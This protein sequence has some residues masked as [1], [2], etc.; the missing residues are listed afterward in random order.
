[1]LASLSSSLRAGLLGNFTASAA[2][3]PG[4]EQKKAPPAAP[5][6]ALGAWAD[7]VLNGKRC[8]RLGWVARA[9]MSMLRARAGPDQ[10]SLR[11]G[12]APARCAV[13]PTHVHT[14]ART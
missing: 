6:S 10:G 3:P 11:P 8:A 9:C 12:P 13:A 1:M 2:G 5:Y 7:E 4:T 14:R